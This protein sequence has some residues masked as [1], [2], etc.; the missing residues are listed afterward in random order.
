MEIKNSIVL[1]N[2]CRFFVGALF[3]FSGFVKIVDPIGTAIKLEKYFTIFSTNFSDFFEIFLPQTLPIAIL[4]IASEIILGFALLFLYRMNITS[5]ALLLLI[6]FF[7]LLTFYTA[8]TGAPKDCGCFGDFLKLTPWTSFGKDVILTLM[9]FI[10]FL[11]RFQF[12]EESKLDNWTGGGLMLMLSLSTFYFA[13]YN[14][15][16]LP[17]IDFRPYA[18][19]NY[20]PDLMNNGKPAVV[21]YKVKKGDE[22]IVIE[23]F[24]MEY[25]KPPYEYLGTVTIEEPELSTIVDFNLY[26]KDGELKT[27]DVLKGKQLFIVIRKLEP[28]SHENIVEKLHS[29]E[30]ECFKNG[31]NSQIIGS[32]SYDSFLHQNFEFKGSFLTLDTD[33]SKAVVRSK[34]GVLLLDN[35]T[36]KGKWHYNDIPTFEEVQKILSK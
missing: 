12:E 34:V 28:L 32:I 5:W 14:L 36:V 31:I 18:V 11:N 21:N 25:A 29:L 7:T 35:A 9:I 16:H 13:Y 4:L 33:I 8:V 19:G 6:I 10:I 24:T 1:R 30:E 26:N 15:A 17:V 3:L 20:L 2:I 27:D 23:Q 22:E